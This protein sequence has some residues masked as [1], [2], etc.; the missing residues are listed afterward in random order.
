VQLQGGDEPG[1]L[2]GASWRYGA[3]RGVER[4]LAGAKSHTTLAT[5]YGQRSAY[6]GLSS[7]GVFQFRH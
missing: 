2:T 3:G 5:G 1:Q 4:F 6:S 7:S